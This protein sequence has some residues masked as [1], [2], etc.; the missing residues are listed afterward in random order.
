MVSS[1]SVENIIILAAGGLAAITGAAIGKK[2]T[3]VSN[4]L[5]LGGV[6]TVGCKITSV[7]TNDTP[8]LE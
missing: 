6:V 7:W 4:F 3:I 8:V 5:I 2:N 1:K